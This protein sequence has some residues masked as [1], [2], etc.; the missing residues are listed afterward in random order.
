MN[1]ITLNEV[2][3]E[4]NL[5]IVRDYE[6]IEVT[7]ITVPDVTRPGLQLAGNFEHFIDRIQVIGN[8]KWHISIRCSRTIACAESVLCSRREYLVLSCRVIMWHRMK[9]SSVR[10]VIESLFCAAKIRRPRL[11]VRS[12]NIST[13]NWL[14]GSRCMA[15][16]L[17]FTVKAS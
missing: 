13:S 6:K 7:E 16:S 1:T 3:A 17:R 4:F 14:Q 15:C 10:T 12:S 11:R 8:M 9:C 2:I 5:E